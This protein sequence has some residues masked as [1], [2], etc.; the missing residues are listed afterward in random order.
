MQSHRTTHILL[1]FVLLIGAFFRFYKITTVPPSLSH[2]EV[3]IAYNAYSIL[4]TGKDEY[5]K[6]FPLLFQS[7]DD[8]KLPGMV[9]LTV[10][11][12][13][14][15]GRSALGARFP[16]AFM[17]TLTLL[18]VYALVYELTRN[19]THG[20]NLKHARLYA[21]SSAFFFAISPWHINFSR[22]LFESNG[23]L[24]ILSLATYV[25]LVSL[26]NIRFL[27]LSALFFAISVYFYYSVRLVIP[28][29]ALAYWFVNAQTIKKK[30]PIVLLS[31]FLFTVTILPIGSLMFTRGGLERVSI[32][33]LVKDPTFY[34]WK[35]AFIHTYARNP[36]IVRKIFFNQKTALIA[37]AVHNYWKNISPL[38]VFA[39]G[40]TTYGLQ[41]PFEIP[42]SFVGIIVLLGFSSPS[43][44]ILM[45]WFMAAFLPGALSTNQPNALRTLLAAPLFS[46]C[47]GIGAIQLYNVIEKR[48]RFLYGAVSFGLLFAFF[49]Y[50]FY[51]S[52][53]IV[54]PTRNALAFADGYEQMIAYVRAH[55]SR[56]DRIVISGYYWRPYIFMLYWGNADPKLYQQHGTRN[57]WGKY[58][59][60]GAEWD[61]NEAF[62]YE[63]SFDPKQLVLS[64]PD[65]TLFILANSE[66]ATNQSRYISLDTINGRHAPSVFIAALAK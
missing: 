56:Y 48:K 59:F 60:T 65:K 44:W 25:L 34:M 18:V 20:R 15:F 64:S 17:G 8:Y 45:A 19:L 47:S 35:D 39:S 33:S 41:H 51:Q 42:L 63:T 26:R 37:A 29:I 9:Y 61:T 53:F 52:Y 1:F 22:Q 50:T 7:F 16:S 4:K 21:L 36:T 38:H 27:L 58:I 46:I 62:L 49:I 13:A 23:A 55:E 5:G 30:L 12:V 10:P 28:C 40:T 66:Y 11:A 32:V 57:G 31:V 6:S 24:F 43:K 2:D 3:A 54:N 14:A